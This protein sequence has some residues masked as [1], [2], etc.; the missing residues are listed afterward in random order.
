MASTISRAR[1]KKGY[2]YVDNDGFKKGVLSWQARGLLITILTK[3]DNWEVRTD[4]LVNETKGTAKETAINGVHTIL[5]EL[6]HSSFVHYRKFRD[7]SVSYLFF[8]YEATLDDANELWVEMGHEALT[9]PYPLSPIKRKP[10]KP[11]PDQLNANQ[12]NTDDIVS[13]ERPL[14]TER[15]TNIETTQMPSSEEIAEAHKENK[16]RDYATKAASECL[17]LFELWVK[18]NNKTAHTK[19]EGQNK[20]KIFTAWKKHGFEDCKKLII[21]NY[22][23]DFN[24]ARGKYKGSEK[25]N[26]LHQIFAP[27]KFDRYM[28]AF[29]DSKP[30]DS[31][32]VALST[33]GCRPLGARDHRLG[34]TP[35]ETLQM[36]IAANPNGNKPRPTR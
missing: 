28:T 31:V 4:A 7:G 16:K 17:G 26:F 14:S 15:P 25:Q 9:E 12:A 32:K 5:R 24:Q 10:I 8:D 3:P 20:K 23:L 27:T 34:N 30:M 35:Q 21:G 6:K 33:T 19:F 18:L 13:T 22:N 36:R 11:N 1:R 29:Y 2:T